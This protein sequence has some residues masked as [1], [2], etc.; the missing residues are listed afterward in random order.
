[1]GTT[2]AD[3]CRAPPSYRSLSDLT[4]EQDTRA[5]CTPGGLNIYERCSRFAISARIGLFDQDHVAA[6]LGVVENEGRLGLVGRHGQGGEILSPVLAVFPSAGKHQEADRCLA[7]SSR[8]I[9]DTPEGGV[10]LNAAGEG[11][12][13]DLQDLPC[14]H[15]LAPRHRAGGHRLGGAESTRARGI[16]GNLLGGGIERADAAAHG[17]RNARR[18]EPH[19]DVCRA[20]RNQ[21]VQTALGGIAHVKRA[22]VLV[23]AV[24]GRASCTLAVLACIRHGALVV[25]VAGRCIILGLAALGR[26]AE[27][28]GA[29]VEVITFHHF[30][31]ALVAH[32]FFSGAGVLV[33]ALSVDGTRTRNENV[34]TIAST[35][36]AEID[37]I[38]LVVVAGLCLADALVAGA[39]VRV[40]AFVP[41][42]AACRVVGEHAA[43]DGVTG[44]A[45]ADEVVVAGH[46]G[47]SLTCR[48]AIAGVVERADRAIG[49]NSADIR[50]DVG[51][52][53]GR[54]AGV[55]RANVAVVTALRLDRTFA[56]LANIA[57]G[58]LVGIVARR[59]IGRVLA[60]LNAVA[61][62]VGA[63]VLVV[64]HSQCD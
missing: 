56:V 25:V 31:R 37:G 19:A 59:G 28:V 22:R 5:H 58:A 4:I 13:V 39:R 46:R 63:G 3:N 30:R 60:A 55:E 40:R 2:V 36:V 14:R 45:R 44:I 57:F 61:E 15:V 33:V 53:L 42:V 6:A 35:T 54:V 48:L 64:A 49:T 17:C 20:I 11:V 12:G 34:L 24:L 51:T 23:V 50:G 41:V 16:A 1:M 32:A 9:G 8:A 21:D 47:T 26:V 62:I 52:A 7:I 27:V 10:G 29:S 38:A 43:F 18:R